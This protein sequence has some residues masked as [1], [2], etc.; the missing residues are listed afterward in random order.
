ML[1]IWLSMNVKRIMIP[2]HLKSTIERELSM[3]PPILCEGW[4]T[5]ERGIE[6]AELVLETKPDTIVEIGCFGARSTIAMALALRENGKGKIYTID[7]WKKEA[8]LEGENQANQEWWDRVD[9]NW[10][11]NKAMEA[12]WRNGLDGWATVIREH[13]Q[14]I[15]G[16]FNNIDMLCID[17]N[18]SEVASSRDVEA[19]LPLVRYGGAIWFDDSNWPSTQ[20]ALSMIEKQCKLFKDGGS[21]RVYFKNLDND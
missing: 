21:Y 7:P 5:P 3:S 12:I 2:A 13:S 8:A 10:I 19:F 4:T 15:I 6:M 11:H 9:L 17:G 1:P 14:N 18:H 16:L 20:L